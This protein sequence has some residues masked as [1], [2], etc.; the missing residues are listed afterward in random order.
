MRK[1][2]WRPALWLMVL[3]LVLLSGTVAAYMIR[4]TGQTVNNFSP[5]VVQC[6]V[7]EA[8]DGSEK[9][10]I[11]VTN[12]GNTDAYLRLRLVTYW[13]D[14]NGNI[15]G[16]RPSE[17]ISLTPASGWFSKEKDT[18]YYP[19]PI[20][21][22]GTTPNLLGSP[23]VLKAEDGLY[24][25]IEVFAE[26]IQSLPSDAVESSWKVTVSDGKIQ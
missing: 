17:D 18:W 21:P 15:S 10:S 1:K 13:V 3:L 8:F 7:A 14:E 11:R 16:S 22:G 2:L 23:L 19:E 25:V 9:S 26:A 5:A 4:R 20:A 24:Q 12:T 6:Q